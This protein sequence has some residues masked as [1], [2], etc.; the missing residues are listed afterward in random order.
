MDA[1]A[2]ANSLELVQQIL[3]KTKRPADLSDSSTE[4]VPSE[5][6]CISQL[7]DQDFS[8]DTYHINQRPSKRLRS[9]NEPHS[10][11][12]DLNDQGFVNVDRAMTQNVLAKVEALHRGRND[13]RPEVID[14]A[15]PPIDTE[16]GWFIHPQAINLPLCFPARHL[17]FYYQERGLSFGKGLHNGSCRLLYDPRNFTIKRLA[18]NVRPV[19]A[20]RYGLL[21]IDM[22]DSLLLLPEWKILCGPQRRRARERSRIDSGSQDSDKEER[23]YLGVMKHGRKQLQWRDASEP[24]CDRAA[25]RVAA[26]YLSM[27]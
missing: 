6:Q 1:F 14:E 18:L 19:Y 17:H 5:V 12:S 11:Q 4:R 27:H 2:S 25:K 3:A 13:D 20:I 16:F 8:I 23:Q 24:K 22:G 7:E 9:D 21:D 10:R 26:T 15:A